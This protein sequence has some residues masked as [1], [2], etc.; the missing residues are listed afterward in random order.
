MKIERGSERMSS[1]IPDWEKFEIESCSYLNQVYGEKTL[2]FTS[3]G[4]KDA[5]ASDITVNYGDRVLFSIEAKYSPSQSGQFVL[6]EENGQYILSNENRLG[7]NRY[8]QIIIDF[9]NENKEN[10]SPIGQKAV[11]INGIQHALAHWI[12]EHYKKKDSYFVITST[13][14]GSYKAI[15]PIDEINDYFDISAVVRRK[16]SGTSDVAQ[17]KVDGCLKELE[18]F[19][20]KF[21]LEISEV[22]RAKKTSVKFNKVIELKKA[23]RYFGENFFLS[24]N[25]DGVSYRIKTKA[26]TNNVNVVFSLKYR[27]PHENMGNDLL[28]KFIES[29]KLVGNQLH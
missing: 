28:Q 17:Y 15:I 11:R 8:T 21:G 20:E 25:S 10:Y 6:T 9:L 12:I 7:N 22:S 27:G 29:Q 24:P 13:V 23:D 18:S 5:S 3:K 16:K 14:L 2:F 1:K 4:G 19:I 26:K